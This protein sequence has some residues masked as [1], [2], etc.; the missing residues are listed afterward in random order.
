MD[1]HQ[2]GGIDVDQTAALLL[3]RRQSNEVAENESESS[4]EVQETL[5]LE[6]T[7]EEV[8][9]QSE[10]SESQEEQELSSEETQDGEQEEDATQAATFDNVYEIAEALDM[11]VDEFLSSIQVKTKVDGQE[12]EVSLADLQKGYQLEA[13]YTRKNQALIESQ[14]AFEQEQEQARTELKSELEKAGMAFGLA[15]QQLMAEFQSIDWASLEKSDPTQYMLARQ[16][17]GE[18][19]AQIDNAIQQASQQAEEAVK[20]QQQE[21]EEQQQKFAK[22]QH[23]LLLKAVPEWN[24]E[25]VRGQADA[26]L[27][28]YLSGMG[29]TDA[30]LPT[31]ADHRFILLAKQ[32]MTA[33]KQVEKK[34]I[35]KKKL[36]RV[37]KL[38]KPSA[39]QDK[40][41]A[42]KKLLAKL[43]NKAKTSGKTSDLQQLLLARRG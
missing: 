10:E 37:P 29:F 3:E 19:N 34:D 20:K 11:P 27:T 33:S 39:P 5:E 16:K 32:A 22:E 42:R 35:A 31:F 14:K 30:D 24:D 40:G 25:V 18:R 26:E 41:A 8:L 4:E 6:A 36:E 38:L 23:E 12:Q 15:K 21:A 2:E 28:N 43:S 17:F 13:N 1:T 7:E 9:D